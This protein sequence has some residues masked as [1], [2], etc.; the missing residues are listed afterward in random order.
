MI[1]GKSSTTQAQPWFTAG[2]K[3]TNA[4]G[5][6]YTFN[7]DPMSNLV[8]HPGTWMV[9]RYDPTQYSTGDVVVTPTP[10]LSLTGSHKNFV[11]IAQSGW[12]A[13]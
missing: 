8:V 5:I 4:T 12:I 6:E 11:H 7:F 9:F 13:F 3:K 2:D 10:A 1:T